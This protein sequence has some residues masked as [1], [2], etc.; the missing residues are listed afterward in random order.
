MPT[1]TLIT[2]GPDCILRGNHECIVTNVELSPYSNWRCNFRSNYHDGSSGSQVGFIQ[3]HDGAVAMK[4]VI[5][6]RVIQGLRLA[7]PRSGYLRV[8]KG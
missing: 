6:G 1:C 3:Q 5:V 8:L 4:K 2:P 7:F